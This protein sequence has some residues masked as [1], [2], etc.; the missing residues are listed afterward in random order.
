[1]KLLVLLLI[2]T[3]L[4]TGCFHDKKVEE[5]PKEEVKPPEPPPSV[6]PPPPVEIKEE[7]KVEPTAEVDEDL[8]S[9]DLGKAL[10]DLD[11]INTLNLSKEIIQ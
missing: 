4:F 1:M 8:F 7:P 5:K 6:Q 11:E 2:G 9:D 3:L 10:E